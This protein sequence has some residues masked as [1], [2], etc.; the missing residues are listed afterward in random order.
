[1]L[2]SSSTSYCNDCSTYFHFKGLGYVTVVPGGSGT[3]VVPHL[4]PLC[5][6]HLTSIPHSLKITNTELHPIR[7]P[8]W[9]QLIVQV[10]NGSSNCYFYDIIA[11][12]QTQHSLYIIHT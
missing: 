5:S 9:M 4:G 8:L 1:M 2:K 3:P 11:M 6:V 12:Y 10:Y 7:V